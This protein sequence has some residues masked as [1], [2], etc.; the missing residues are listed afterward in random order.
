MATT[1]ETQT[2]II[3]GGI[4]GATL[5]LKLA[6]QQQKVTLID[7][8]PELTK[9]QWQQKL[10][11][12]DAR[13]FALSIASIELLKQV[14]AWQLIAQSGRK[15]DYTQMQ[16]WQQDGKGELNFGDEYVPQLLGSM[17][18]PFVIEHALYQR[19]AAEDVSEYLTLV[20]GHKV[21]LLDWLG[22]QQGYQVHLDNGDKLQGKLLIGAD[23]RG[24]LVRR[25]AG[26]GLD[27]L[28]YNQTAICCAIK[29]QQPHRA[30]ARQLMLPTGTLA[31]L[32]LADVT[33]D[34]KA[35]PQHW[36]S[37][38]WSLPRNR[39]LELL[40]LN[41]EDD[42]T[43]R[44]ELAAASQYAL[45]DIEQLESIAS[46]PL[47]AQQAKHYVK[48]NLVLVGDAA[49]GV[50]PLAGQGL[51]LGM[52]DVAALVEELMADYERSGGRCWGELATLRRYERTRRPHNSVMMHSFSLMNWLFAGDFA[53]LRPVQQ[54]RSEGMYQV[55]KI[56]PLMRFFT[57]K[58]SGL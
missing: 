33:E 14:G 2:L 43:L 58:A 56:K 54:I 20:A 47:N 35:N 12:R 42:D 53:A 15:A 24:S 52:L 49:H 21:T 7:A 22:S 30:T 19:M 40:Q 55:G 38:V 26:I 3:G 10:L 4:V 39:A 13:V 51:N 36:Q 34:D 31:L 57:Q 11:Q 28:D 48:E 29:T 6:Q 16:V 25:E 46:F 9:E 32:P 18:E 17:V 8:R 5:A 23:G 45:G 50:H 41:E 37:V 1:T 44:R 27:T